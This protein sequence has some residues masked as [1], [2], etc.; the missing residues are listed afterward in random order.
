MINIEKMIKKLK[1]ENERFDTLESQR[2]ANEWRIK[3]LKMMSKPKGPVTPYIRLNPISERL[4]NEQY[5]C[6]P[7]KLLAE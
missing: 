5:S 6:T 7:N 2:E 3:Y 1:D 4:L